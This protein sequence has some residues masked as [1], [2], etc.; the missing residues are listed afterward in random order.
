MKKIRVD[1]MVAE[2]GLAESRAQAQRLIMAGMVL[3]NGDV[4]LKPSA[5]YMSDVSIVLKEKP[6]FVSRGGDKLLPALQ[7]FN[8]ENLTNMVCVDVGAS[9]GG[10]TDCMLQH[11]ALRVYSIDVGYGILH[12][13]LRNDERVI[14]MER[15][16]AR[17]LTGLPEP[18][19]LV[20]VDASFISLKVLLPVIKEWYPE[21]G[22]S[23]IV[24]IKPQ[25]E[26]G[27]KEAARGEGVIRDPQIHRR[28]ILDVLRF[29]E[30]QGYSI[31][32]LIRSPLQGPKGNIEFLANLVR[33]KDMLGEDINGLIEKQNLPNGSG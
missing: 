20:T 9:T 27:R 6:R 12:W 23:A 15:T 29:A 28:V 19:N 5:T 16:N 22:G 4:A 13:K 2:Q 33:S 32:D 1:I 21:E 18:V 3:V 11:G 7:K 10:F 14:V 26:A 25:F 31:T 8:Q 30:S 17:Y 24:L